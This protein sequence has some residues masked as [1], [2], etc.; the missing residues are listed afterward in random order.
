MDW[1]TLTQPTILDAHAFEQGAL[2]KMDLI[3][4]I[5]PRY[6]STYFNHIWASGYS[7]GYY[8]YIWSAVLDSDAYQAFKEVGNIFDQ[9]TADKFRKE[10][11]SRG[12]IQDGGVL[13]RNFRGRDPKVEALLDDLGLR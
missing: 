13:Y 8:A 2:A 11:L 1:H 4:E 7:A 9:A 6:R 10:I 5:P 3:K 12:G